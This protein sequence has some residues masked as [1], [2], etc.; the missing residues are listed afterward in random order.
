MIFAEAEGLE[1]GEA[2]EGAGGDGGEVVAVEVDGLEGDE[3]G[4]GRDGAG[5]GVALEGE[6][7]QLG[8]G[9][10]IRGE[11]AGEGGG[12]ELYDGDPGGGVAADACPLAVGLARGPA[13]RL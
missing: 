4:E 5:E 10:K 7:L 2:L 11:G 6:A 8:E 9:G 3:A 1:A 12:R 13:R